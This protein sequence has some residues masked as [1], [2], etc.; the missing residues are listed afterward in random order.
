MGTA[1][2]DYQESGSGS[3]PA[4]IAVYPNPV[5]SSTKIQLS[6]EK[7]ANVAISVVNILG[8]EVARFNNLNFNRGINN[9]TWN[10]SSLSTGTYFIRVNIGERVL[11]KKVIVLH[12]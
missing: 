9:I 3:I 1:V 7:T 11:T 8:Q 10:T 4:S 12:H 6:I 2:K 5:S